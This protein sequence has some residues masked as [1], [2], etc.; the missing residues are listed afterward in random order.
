MPNKKILIVAD[1]QVVKQNIP[2]AAMNDS[3]W[4]TEIINDTARAGE[5]LA[6]SAPDLLVTD[7]AFEGHT[8]GFDLVR[9][10]RE[11]LQIDCP[12]IA[13]VSVADSPG[14]NYDPHKYGDYFP[15]EEFIE[16]PAGEKIDPELFVRKIEKLLG[17]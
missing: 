6:K 10:A 7:L 11:K 1:A 8:E 3:R 5:W 15:V 16:K 9:D 4:E 2:D 13:F 12:I 14:Y 17:L